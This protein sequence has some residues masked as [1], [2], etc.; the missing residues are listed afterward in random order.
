[1]LLDRV[2][3]ALRITH[4]KLDEDIEQHISACIAEL[5]RVGVEVPDDTE[6]VAPLLETAVKIYVMAR[7]DYLGKGTQYQTDYEK[8]R[9]AL[10][11]SQ[12]YRGD[13][14]VQ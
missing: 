3:T 12:K 14:D 1:M 5:D 13:S 11:L 6:A 9:D 7:Y 4:S 8:L 10:S 2:K